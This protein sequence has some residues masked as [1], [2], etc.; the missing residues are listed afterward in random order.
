MPK[1]TEVFK[2]EVIAELHSGTITKSE[3]GKKYDVPTGTLS[4]WMVRYAQWQEQLVTLAVMGSEKEE[5]I[6]DDCD[7]GQNLE[8]IQ[9][10]LRLATI[11]LA[12]L[13]ALIDETEKDL[14]ID[15]RKKGGTRSSV[16]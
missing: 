3:L 4:D 13:E 6:K 10:A 16:A 14:G 11:K 9:E 8:S 5:L 12:C 15:I 7:H 1:Y 2:R